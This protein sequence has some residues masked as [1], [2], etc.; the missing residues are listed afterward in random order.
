MPIIIIISTRIAKQYKQQL[1]K[2]FIG[3]FLVVNRFRYE[4]KMPLLA[5]HLS[6][7]FD[8]PSC[9]SI[10]GGGGLILVPGPGLTTFA[11]IIVQEL[12]IGPVLL[13]QIEKKKRMKIEKKMFN[14]DANDVYLLRKRF[15]TNFSKQLV[16]QAIVSILKSFKL[17]CDVASVFSLQLFAASSRFVHEQAIVSN[18][19]WHYPHAG[20]DPLRRVRFADGAYC[21]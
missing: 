19:I 12:D 10:C 3:H 7:R 4:Y 13:N 16:D 11:F 5:N 20:S 14:F 18:M 21:I 1:V 2:N 17:T 8:G 9:L 15:K 6:F